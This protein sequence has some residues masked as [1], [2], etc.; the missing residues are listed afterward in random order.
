M[1]KVVQSVKWNHAGK[2]LTKEHFDAS[3]FFYTLLLKHNI[4]DV[5]EQVLQVLLQLF[6]KLNCF[7]EQ[8]ITYL[9]SGRKEKSKYLLDHSWRLT[10]TV[11]ND[12]NIY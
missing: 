5:L 8:T 12:M 9:L 4:G 7:K 6:L 3:V 1:H 10:V 2:F 11:L